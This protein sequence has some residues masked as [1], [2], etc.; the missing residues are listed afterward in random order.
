VP[1]TAKLKTKQGQAHRSQVMAKLK[2]HKQSD[3][4]HYAIKAG[5]AKL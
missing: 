3:L 4:V 2:L 1:T 5:I